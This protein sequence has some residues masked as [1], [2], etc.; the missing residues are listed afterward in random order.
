MSGANQLVSGSM[1]TGITDTTSA[2][3]V[4]EFFE[5]NYAKSKQGVDDRYPSDDGYNWV[6]TECDYATFSVRV[7]SCVAKRGSGSDTGRVGRW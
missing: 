5:S 2:I 1:S 3:A 4:Q 6:T 7:K